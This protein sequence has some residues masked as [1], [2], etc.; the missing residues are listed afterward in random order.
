MM[1]KAFWTVRS[2]PGS[3][4]WP[5]FRGRF[6]A[7]YRHAFPYVRGRR[8]ID[9]ASG[10]G[11]GSLLLATEGGASVVTGVE[12]D[13]TAVQYARKHFRANNL[14]F[15]CSD[16]RLLKDHFAG[17]S[18]DVV[19]SMGTL[20]HVPAPD[21][22]A[23]AVGD[24]LVQNGVWLV[25]ML[26]AKWPRD[27]DPYHSQEWDL[28]TFRQFLEQ[29]FQHVTILGL[30]QAPLAPPPATATSTLRTRVPPPVKRAVLRLLPSALVWRLQLAGEPTREP[31]HYTWT[32]EHVESAMEFL[33]IC[34][35]PL[36]SAGN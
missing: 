1:T 21:R 36:K 9:V 20:E 8:V 3:A 10:T 5:F 30:Q 25:T 2:V 33:G 26:N 19:V 34:V 29:H 16:G 13:Q 17:N 22:F 15:L 18:V 32:E 23:S 11:Y 28:S 24:I 6:L 31:E 4:S 14:T 35:G 7:R 27:P 12:I